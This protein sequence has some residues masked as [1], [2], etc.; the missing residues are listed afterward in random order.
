MAAD[1]GTPTHWL[2]DL[3]NL[4]VNVQCVCSPETAAKRF[5]E[6]KRH[7]GHLDGD[8]TYANVLASLQALAA[9]DALELGPRLDVDTSGHVSIDNLVR[10]IQGVFTR[11]NGRG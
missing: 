11:C 8:A 2:R 3:S 10:E 5:L 4:V 1:S 9:L 7:A 6:R